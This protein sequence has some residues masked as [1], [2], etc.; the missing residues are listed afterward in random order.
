MASTHRCRF[1]SASCDCGGT[2]DGCYGCDDCV[3]GD[4]AD[5]VYCALCDLYL[6][7]DPGPLCDACRHN[8]QPDP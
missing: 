8:V 1:C 5:A 2:V 7:G 3:A 4:A 6:E